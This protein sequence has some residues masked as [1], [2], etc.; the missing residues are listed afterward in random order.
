MIKTILVNTLNQIKAEE[1]QAVAQAV[2]KNKSEIVAPKF[3]EIDSAKNKA[4]AEVQSNAN[5]QIAELNKQAADAK[6]KFEEEQKA[7]VT[8]SVQAQYEDSISKLNDQIASI[9]E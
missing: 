4:I 9:A 3:A 1:S 7:A 6:V 8:A 2:S 5:A